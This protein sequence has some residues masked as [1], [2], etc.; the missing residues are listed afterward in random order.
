MRGI[1]PLFFLIL[2]FY[3]SI[4]QE[5]F[6]NWLFSRPEGW[7]QK[8][9]NNMVSLTSPDQ[10]CVI[11]LLPPKPMESSLDQN[12]KQGWNEHVQKGMGINSIAVGQY[13][14]ANDGLESI[15]Q[16]W[17]GKQQGK[18]LLIYFYTYKGIKQAEYLMIMSA[19]KVGYDQNETQLNQFLSSFQFSDAQAL[20]RTTVPQAT[21]VVS[22][23]GNPIVGKWVNH[24]SMSGA[25][26]SVAIFGN[27]EGIIRQL[28]FRA[29]GTYQFT[30]LDTRP[31]QFRLE[32]SSGNYRASVN[33][34][35]LLG[36]LPI[37]II[38]PV[39]S[40][41]RLNQAVQRVSLKSPEMYFNYLITKDDHFVVWE[42]NQWEFSFERVTTFD[43][44]ENRFL[45]GTSPPP[46]VAGSHGTLPAIGNFRGKAPSGVYWALTTQLRMGWSMNPNGTMSYGN[47]TGNSIGKDLYFLVL[48]DD[49]IGYWHSFLPEQGLHQLHRPS[50]T[51]GRYNYVVAGNS[52]KLMSDN[53]DYLMSMK[54]VG[55]TLDG[56]DYY[57]LP[58]VD[59]LMLEGSWYR[60]D[61][62]L[63]IKKGSYTFGY[64]T[65][66]KEGTFKDEGM[67]DTCSD[68]KA[69]QGT[70][71][72]KDYTLILKFTDGR[73]E[74]IT[75]YSL[76][77]PVKDEA[78]IGSY[79]ISR[80][81]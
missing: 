78:F 81:R 9:E 10:R 37:E 76:Q 70:Y 13:Q 53:K 60:S 50:L 72:I 34:Y 30:L 5:K 29:D 54:E 61:F 40:V 6:N 27:T 55:L 20:L 75:F 41:Q 69:G 47:T 66:T 23:T 67:L 57:P 62:Y 52:G 56:D 48:Y 22:P 45:Q 24:G 77:K 18:D 79:S 58:S 11:V 14:K 74:N 4:G 7:S 31:D 25:S 3:N 46:V 51:F 68:I 32:K 1:I 43:N 64:L 26:G 8:Q 21:S 35:N 16:G 73:N 2:S 49:G 39:S 65:F 28:E 17:S 12:F 15:A 19:G 44:L 36:R 38:N 80:V 42:N 71:Q 59:N 63:E 33:E